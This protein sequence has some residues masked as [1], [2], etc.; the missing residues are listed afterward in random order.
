M[1]S[2]SL[3]LCLIN[4]HF[5]N[6][7]YVMLKEPKLNQTDPYELDSFNYVQ[8]ANKSSSHT[9]VSSF[10]QRRSLGE[11]HLS[12]IR[13]KLNQ[14]LSIKIINEEEKYVYLVKNLKEYPGFVIWEAVFLGKKD[15]F[16][17]NQACL[18]LKKSIVDEFLMYL[19]LTI[20]KG[21]LTD[22]YN[23]RLG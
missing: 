3:S 8:K 12:F 19:K 11:A 23:F 13:T 16:V 22:S 2:L 10:Q 15:D 20:L 7:K 1:I 17:N 21:E 6:N 5:L 4:K 14:Q 18:R 9:V